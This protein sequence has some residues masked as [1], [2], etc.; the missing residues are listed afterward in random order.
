MVKGFILKQ[1]TALC[2]TIKGECIREWP[3]IKDA[4]LDNYLT[5]HDT[6]SI[7]IRMDGDPKE[8]LYYVN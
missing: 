7:H 8:C 4:F 3:I 1:D 5:S 2:V 6:D